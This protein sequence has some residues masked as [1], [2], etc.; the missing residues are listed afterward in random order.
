MIRRLSKK[1]QRTEKQL[2]EHYEVE[3][4]LADRLRNASRNERRTLYTSL[5]E[6]LCRLI[7]NHPTLTQKESPEQ[8]QKAV[9]KQMKILSGC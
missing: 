5:Y 3:R 1:E 9:K 7:P 6:E 2:W 4:E 8:Q